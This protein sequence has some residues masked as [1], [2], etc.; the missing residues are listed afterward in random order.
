MKKHHGSKLRLHRDT[1]RSLTPARL[2]PAVGMSAIP[3]TN[4]P[5]YSCNC[6]PGCETSYYCP[7]HQTCG[8]LYC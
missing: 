6:T 5:T 8:T 3:C 7:T 4:Q 1:V 2:A